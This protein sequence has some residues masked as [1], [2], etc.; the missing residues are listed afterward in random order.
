MLCNIYLFNLF[1]L[2]DFTKK[3]LNQKTRSNIYNN[4]KKKEGRKGCKL[5]GNLRW[6][7]I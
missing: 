7:T 5:G 6:E 2:L 4:I 1:L 3:K